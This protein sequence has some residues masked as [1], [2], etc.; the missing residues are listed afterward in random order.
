MSVGCTARSDVRDTNIS[1]EKEAHA[2]GARMVAGPSAANGR[3]PAFA[4]IA[5]DWLDLQRGMSR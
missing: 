5:Q 3:G 4:Q 2:Y 1:T